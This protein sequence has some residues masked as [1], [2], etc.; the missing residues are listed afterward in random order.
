VTATP[1]EDGDS[2]EADSAW[3]PP[4]PFQAQS[5]ADLLEFPGIPATAKGVPSG[6]RGVT[7]PLVDAI[8]LPTI[9][10]PEQISSAVELAA[11][12]KCRLYALYTDNV[13]AGLLTALARLKRDA[14]TP[15]VVRSDP[16]HHL[17]DLAADLPQSLASSAARDISRKRNVGLLIGRACG[18]TRMLFLDDDIRRLNVAKLSS[19]AALLDK[20]P[21]VGLQVKKYPDASVVGHARRL[22]G[23][24]QEPFVSGGSLLVNPQ[25]LNGFFAPVYHEDWLCII[26]HLRLGEVAIGGAVGQLPYQP[27]VTSERARFEEFGEILASGLLWLVHARGRTRAAELAVRS[28]IPPVAEYDYWREATRPIFWEEILQHRGALLDE[29]AARLKDARLKEMNPSYLPPLR[30]VE[31]AR[32]RFHEL[33]PDEFVSFTKR[34]VG[35]LTLWRNRLS[36]LP[37]VDSVEKALAELGLMEVVRMQRRARICPRP[38]LSPYVTSRWPGH[39]GARSAAGHPV[40]QLLFHVECS[41]ASFSVTAWYAADVTMRNGNGRLLRAG[42]ACNA[43]RPW[44]VPGFCEKTRQ[45]C[46]DRSGQHRRCRRVRRESR[47][48]GKEPAGPDNAAAAHRR[49]GAGLH[50]GAV[51]G[52]AGELLGAGPDGRA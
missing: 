43:G 13:P 47:R 29:I 50:P 15:L 44:L 51:A 34:W 42:R 52:D 41:R 2:R 20:F 39:D 32:H 46:H 36:H 27:F 18:W 26:N 45:R 11:Q 37:R 40:L 8:I 9:R 21:V 28:G 19:A 3:E 31:A 6:S 17:L 22:T 38:A 16:Q 33:R 1:G 12:A 14:V 5:Y 48:A 10:T 25:R 24:R 23:R 35:S 4:K 49:G 7:V 30:S